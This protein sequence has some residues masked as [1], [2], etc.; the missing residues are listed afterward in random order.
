MSMLLNRKNYNF[1]KQPLDIDILLLC[2]N[3][4][5][6]IAKFLRSTVDYPD[7]YTKLLFQH[8]WHEIHI[9]KKDTTIEISLL[10]KAGIF[11]RL[12]IHKCR[13]KEEQY[14]E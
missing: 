11:T 14:F 3:L 13:N 4:I 12:N 10:K 1:Q 9:E 5:L 7:I 6:N 8:R 2:I